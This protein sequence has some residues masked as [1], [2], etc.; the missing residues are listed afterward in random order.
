MIDC[1]LQKSNSAI[2]ENNKNYFKKCLSEHN[3]KFL[4]EKCEDK[5][6]KF[7]SLGNYYPEIFS[8]CEVCGKENSSKK[9]LIPSNT[10][11]SINEKFLNKK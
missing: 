1:L 11:K 3:T 5:L 10:K 7:S 8:N 2:L 6:E 9:L 4:C